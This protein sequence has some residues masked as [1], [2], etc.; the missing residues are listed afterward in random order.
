MKTKITN[1]PYSLIMQA[2][3]SEV[4]MTAQEQ[5]LSRPEIDD[6]VCHYLDGETLKKALQFIDNVYSG[7]MKIKWS[8][9]NVWSV[10]YRFKH[11]CDIAIE[12]GVLKVHQISNNTDVQNTQF[13]YD[14]ESMKRV[15]SV[16]R[17]VLFGNQEVYQ[18]SH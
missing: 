5:L 12:R 18:A 4:G 3:G 13:V 9:V 11:I 17:S 1:N 15:T 10:H 16:L 14:T 2:N 7:G 8:N 6:V